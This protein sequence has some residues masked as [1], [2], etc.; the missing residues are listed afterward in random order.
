MIPP[1]PVPRAARSCADPTGHPVQLRPRR[2][3][4][5][6]PVRRPRRGAC[7]TDRARRA[8]ARGLRRAVRCGYRSVRA[9]RMRT[10]CPARRWCP[11]TPAGRAAD[12]LPLRRT[13]PGRRAPQ[14]CCSHRRRAERVPGALAR[15]DG[16]R[17]ELDRVFP[18]SLPVRA[19]SEVVERPRLTLQITEALIDAERATQVRLVTGVTLR[20]ERPSDH[21]TA[22]RERGLF[23]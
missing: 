12:V 15:L 14:R 10:R 23:T 7:D 21:E 13:G 17:P 1:R 2:S 20:R 22:V 16:P 18:P 19:R 8:G 3:R 4:P 6:R 11:A 5:R 9:V